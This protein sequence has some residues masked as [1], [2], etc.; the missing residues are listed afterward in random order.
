MKFDTLL[1]L[2]SHDVQSYP[3]SVCLSA[4]VGA[5]VKSD[6]KFRVFDRRLNA[7][8]QKAI[9]TSRRSKIA[10]I[11]RR[12]LRLLALDSPLTRFRSEPGCASKRQPSIP[13]SIYTRKMRRFELT[14]GNRFTAFHLAYWLE[15]GSSAIRQ[16]RQ[17]IQA[18]HNMEKTSVLCLKYMEENEQRRLS[19]EPAD[20]INFDLLPICLRCYA[21]R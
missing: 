11:C 20:D 8:T 1:T 14:P 10:K 6:E 17:I 5:N 7:S 15:V 12:R 21:V 13:V 3:A 19:P 2:L 4:Y 9:S 16:D 18:I